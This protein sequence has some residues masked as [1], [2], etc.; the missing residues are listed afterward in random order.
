MDNILLLKDNGINITVQ[1][2]INKATIEQYEMMANW[3]YENGIIYRTNNDLTNSYFDENRQSLYIE[4]AEFNE[5]KSRLRFITEEPLEF[6]QTGTSHCKYDQKR[7]FDCISGKHTFAISYNLHI[8]PCFNIWETE[9][10]WF[11]ASIS[12]EDALDGL[13]E[14]LNNKQG[15][16]MLPTRGQGPGCRS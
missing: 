10:P 9:G 4:T 6:C 12:I 7:H 14:Y 13:K 5:I 15:G 1:T 2:P 11:D 3:C 16:A 8:R